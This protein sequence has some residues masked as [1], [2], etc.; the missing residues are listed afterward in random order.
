M[1]LGWISIH[2]EAPA[3]EGSAARKESP[4]N[5]EGHLFKLPPGEISKILTVLF[6]ISH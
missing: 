2:V 4:V 5:R 3:S 1:A 6:Q